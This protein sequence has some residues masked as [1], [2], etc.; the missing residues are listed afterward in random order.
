MA[1]I[2]TEFFQEKFARIHVLEHQ[3]TFERIP[4]FMTFGGENYVM[5]F[6]FIQNVFHSNG[7]I[8]SSVS[9]L[10][11]FELQTIRKEW[12]KISVT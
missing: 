2:L 3:S 7:S 1:C 9:M 10:V 6:F 11:A 4:N 12:E 8:S 5:F